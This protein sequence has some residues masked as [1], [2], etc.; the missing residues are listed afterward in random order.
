MPLDGHSDLTSAAPFAFQRTKKNTTFE[1][2]TQ[3]HAFEEPDIRQQKAEASS[4]STC[5]GRCRRLGR[6]LLCRRPDPQ[7]RYIRLNVARPTPHHFPS[8]RIVNTK[9]SLLTFLPKVLY[10]QFSYFFNLYFL[11]VAASQFFPPLMLGLRFSYIAPLAFVLVVT[12]SKEAYDDWRRYRKDRELNL[13]TYCRL[14]PGGRT[15]PVHAQDI[16]VGHVLQIQT[17]QRVPADVVLLRTSESSGVVY[18]R[19]D[20]VGRGLQPRGRAGERP[21]CSLTR[22]GPVGAARRRDGVEAA[23]GGGRVPEAVRER[24]GA[25]RLRRDRL[26]LAPLGGHARVRRRHR[27]LRRAARGRRGSGAA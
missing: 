6:W 14:L 13:E 12:M 1:S 21:P 10:E 25:E 22:P 17:N 26:R 4:A 5:G 24:R 2:T 23:A 11:L 27:G 7:S 8:N 15:V 9:Y 20:Q 18:L 3:Y 19:T 16:T